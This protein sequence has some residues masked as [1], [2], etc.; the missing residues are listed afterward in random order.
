MQIVFNTVVF[1]INTKK[2]I[3]HVC[4]PTHFKPML[5]K[6]QLYLIPFSLLNNTSLF[7]YIT[8]CL[9]IHQWMD[10][11]VILWFGKRGGYFS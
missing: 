10:G 9:S 1:T 5:F 7:G 4:G 8:F 11:W 3:T 6:V 2:K